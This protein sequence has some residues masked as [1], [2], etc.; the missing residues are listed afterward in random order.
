[1]LQCQEGMNEC[2]F[3]DAGTGESRPVFSTP[4]RGRPTASVPDHLLSVGQ[5][6][7]PDRGLLLTVRGRL[8]VNTVLAFRD[9]VFSALG[10]H[11]RQ[12]ILDIR[13]LLLVEATGIATLVTL[14]RVAKLMKIPCE[15]QPSPELDA[16]FRE[17]GLDRLMS[18]P[19]PTP[20]QIAQR[21][22]LS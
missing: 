2:V 9:A 10:E 16:V 20:T 5:S 13:P 17:T 21:L 7:Q 12:L 19:P 15:I 4:R 11:P 3:H 22:L 18:A 8:D 1:M 14:S 6:W